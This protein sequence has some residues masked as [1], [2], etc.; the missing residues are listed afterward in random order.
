MNDSFNYDLIINSPKVI[1]SKMKKAEL[2]KVRDTIKYILETN[3][4]FKSPSDRHLEINIEGMITASSLVA[5]IILTPRFRDKCAKKSDKLNRQV[6][7]KLSVPIKSLET[8]LT[9]YVQSILDHYSFLVM[10]DLHMKE[11]VIEYEPGKK[12]AVIIT[13]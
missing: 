5:V 1:S 11:V 3:V 13:T 7:A 6:I 9:K 10:Y 2:L 8:D 4:S 12:P